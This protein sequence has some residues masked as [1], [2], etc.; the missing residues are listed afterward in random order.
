[1]LEPYLGMAGHA[2]VARDD[3]AVFIHLHPM[4][5]V[6]TAAQATFTLRQQ[7]DTAAGAIGSRI[8]AG[9]S[10]MTAMAHSVSGGTIS[11]PYAFPQPGRYRIWV[12]V[13][14]GGKVE[15]AAFDA[16]VEAARNDGGPGA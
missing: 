13:K 9:D 12:Q 10:T 3:G 4:G 2:V 14:R 6:S 8:A 15:T 11:F 5:T 7:G 16:R 1:V